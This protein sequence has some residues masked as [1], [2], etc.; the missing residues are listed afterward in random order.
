MNNIY[1]LPKLKSAFVEENW[2]E[3]LNLLNP[4]IFRISELEYD[5]KNNN[6]Y[7][8]INRCYKI[9]ITNFLI[10]GN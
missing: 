8:F 2:N 7:N 5:L 9:N 3:L 1:L 6:K 4:K 10:L